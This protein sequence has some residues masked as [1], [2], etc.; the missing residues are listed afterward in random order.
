MKSLRDVCQNPARNEQGN[1]ITAMTML[2]RPAVS[3]VAPCFDEDDVLPLF[4][5]GV[6]GVLDSRG[7][8]SELV[9]VGDGSSNRTWELIEEAAL[10]DP[11]RLPIGTVTS[12]DPWLR[13]VTVN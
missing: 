3:V 6:E 12:L 4:L 10:A 5:S 13:E 2:C 9:L 1:Y 7:A 11:R 8:T